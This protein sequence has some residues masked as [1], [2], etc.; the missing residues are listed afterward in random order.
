MTISAVAV[1]G[2]DPAEYVTPVAD[3]FMTHTVSATYQLNDNISLRAG[4]D[5]LTDEEPPYNSSY[6]DA[7]TETTQYKYIGRNFFVGTTITF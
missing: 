5:N 1:N 4:I 3:S 7:N 6:D 2:E